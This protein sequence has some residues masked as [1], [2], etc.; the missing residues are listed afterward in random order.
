MQWKQELA[1]FYYACT[2]TLGEWSAQSKSSIPGRSQWH[3][4]LRLGKHD[5]T[6]KDVVLLPHRVQDHLKRHMH[7]FTCYNS[8][9]AFST[10][11][12]NFDLP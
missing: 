11:R 2:K 9:L 12:S 7:W 6:N 3:F 4:V 1:M 5:L 10:N 8:S